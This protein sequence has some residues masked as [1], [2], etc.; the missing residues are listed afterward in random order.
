[1]TYRPSAPLGAPCWVDLSTSDVDVIREFYCALFDW[2]AEEPSADFGGYF[3]FTRAGRPIAGAMGDTGEVRADNVWKP[4]FSTTD[5]ER[6]LELALARGASMRAP[7]V[8]VGDLGR[9]AVIV[10]VAGATT[11]IWQPDT[12]P[13][14]T[15]VYETGTPSFV[16]IDVHDYRRQVDFYREV[17][18]WSPV[19]EAVDGHHYAGLMDTD[20]HRPLAGI[21]DETESLAPG[22]SPSWSVFWQCEDVESSVATVQSLGGT[23]V[24]GPE[25]GG[26]GL[27]ARVTDPCGAP[28]RLV[29]PRG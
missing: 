14:F 25:R 21:G 1:M 7:V 18:S 22:E 15:T 28:F 4:Y 9:Q 10:D 2:R 19:E 20:A 16:A 13:G 11:G 29:Q 24:S 8:A 3:M 6:T 12:F 26:L 5:V 23:L 27:V 17:F